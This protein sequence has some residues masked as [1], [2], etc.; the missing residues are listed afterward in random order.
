MFA[1][2][3]AEKLYNIAKESLGT[4]KT[5][6]HLI[7]HEV[8][9][10]EALSAVL[11]LAGVWN[12]PSTGIPGTASLLAWLE[13]NTTQFE[14]ITEPEAG[15][16]IISPTGQGNNRIPGHT[17]ILGIRGVQV[18]S[19]F[20]IMSN[21]SNTGLFLEQWTLAKWKQYYQD[22]GGLPIKFFRLK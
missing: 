6:D 11:K 5:L 13:A 14:A 8:G 10:A 2:P 4:N 19:D 9:C 1:T 22:Y 17:G 20:G 15:C 18:P 21:D 16:I 7:P 3:D 12:L